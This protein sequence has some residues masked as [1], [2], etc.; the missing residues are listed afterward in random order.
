MIESDQNLLFTHE[1]ATCQFFVVDTVGE[2]NKSS[3]FDLGTKENPGF[4]YIWRLRESVSE[5]LVCY[6]KFCAC[7]L[8]LLDA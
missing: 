8:W 5:K 7:F 1:I 6:R 2:N 3:R 4:A